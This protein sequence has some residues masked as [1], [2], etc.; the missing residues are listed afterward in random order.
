M[1]AQL[2]VGSVNCL[3]IHFYNYAI[4]QYIK[5]VRTFV[6]NDTN[7]KTNRKIL[8][9][10]FLLIPFSSEMAKTLQSMRIRSSCFSRNISLKIIE[11]VEPELKRIMG[12]YFM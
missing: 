1:T 6:L 11:P 7:T 5:H 10:V 9:M 3:F 2:I 8:R 4:A 12:K